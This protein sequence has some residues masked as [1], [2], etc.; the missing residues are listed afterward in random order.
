MKEPDAK[1]FASDLRHAG[2]SNVKVVNDKRVEFT[3]PTGKRGAYEHDGSWGW[4]YKRL[5]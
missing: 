3:A 5:K 2:A 4:R 1:E